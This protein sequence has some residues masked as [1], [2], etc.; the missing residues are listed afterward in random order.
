[1]SKPAPKQS[2]PQVKESESKR[3]RKRGQ[4]EGSI[5]QRSDGRWSAV[6]W[7]GY[8]NG[9]P[10][11]KSFY[12]RT[13]K[14]A[15]DKMQTASEK[16]R[17]GLPVLTN[18]RQT[19]A[20]FLNRWLEEVARPSV[21]EITHRTYSELV[22]HHLAPGLGK[23]QLVKLNPQD[24][25]SFLNERLKS[26][27][28][29]KTVKH[30]NDTLRAALNVAIK[31]GLIHRNPATLVNPPR[32]EKKEMK[33]FTPEQA[34]T[35]LD[36]IKGHRLEALFWVALTMGLRRGEILGLYWSDIDLDA[37][38]L[39]VNQ[40]LQR[41]NGKLLLSE[42]KTEKSRRALPLPSLLVPILRTHRSRQLEERLRAGEHWQQT[43]FVFTSQV[44]TPIEPRNLNRTFD[45]LLKNAKM[46]RIRFHDCRHTAATLLL[47]KGVSPRTIMEILGHSQIS[48]TM[49]TYS[50]VLPEMT[51]EA[52]NIMDTVMGK[53]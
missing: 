25:Q 42:P 35:F 49:N 52:A 45:A 23:K 9:K 48:L 22:K 16:H 18:E 6:L 36:S 29:P 32:Q 43:D 34:K 10:Q 26:G 14:E 24:I 51:R 2:V 21:R 33:V 12:G 44:G 13:R 19:V 17:K 8:K 28:K 53:K 31:W 46:P 27:L 20:E 37:G 1:M 30:L 40:A 5:Y 7:L 38:T 15:V 41:V 3:R 39:R 4:G 50:H 11:R 47:S